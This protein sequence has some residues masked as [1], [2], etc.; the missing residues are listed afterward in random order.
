M[1]NS[2]EVRRDENTHA[3]LA[4]SHGSR[5]QP[6]KTFGSDDASDELTYL[7]VTLQ[8]HSSQTASKAG[9]TSLTNVARGS[10]SFLPI[11]WVHVPKCGSTFFNALV[12]LPGAV[13]F[14]RS[15]FT[16]GVDFVGM[17]AALDDD[18]AANAFILE[19]N[20][21]CLDGFARWGPDDDWVPDMGV[22]DAA[23]DVT[24]LE[25][26]WPLIGDHSGIGGVYHSKVKGH[27]FIMLRQPEQRIISGYNDEFHSW[28]S[29]HH[30]RLPVNMEEYAKAVSGCA[31]KMMVRP[32]FAA[33]R[34]MGKGAPCGDLL[35]S[36]DTETAQAIVALRS[37]F[38]FVGIQDEWDTSICLLHKMFGGACH[39]SEFSNAHPNSNSSGEPYDTSDLN[40]FLDEHD[41]LLYSAAVQI[42]KSNV[43]KYDA[44]ASGCQECFQLAGKDD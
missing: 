31:V 39:A 22:Y 23:R 34:S 27:G 14:G 8:D 13:A 9:R 37:G 29:W 15:N 10:A 16:A 40:G 36:T 28:P 2:S 35:A 7:Q 6:R 20:D 3:E 38:L 5:L 30:G 1:V 24:F 25:G 21:L 11:A 43:Q 4:R 41:G 12:N 18:I 42:F 33:G 19:L 32:G 26:P 44:S 17:L